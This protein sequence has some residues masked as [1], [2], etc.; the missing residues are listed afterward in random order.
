MI[1]LKAQSRWMDNGGDA[2]ER[3]LM[4]TVT[5]IERTP[6]GVEIFTWSDSLNV[7]DR[8]GFVWRGAIVDF[9]GR[10][11]PLAPQAQPK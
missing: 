8:G 4:H 11:K 7:Q 3:G 5:M 6:A 2:R 10:F 1:E 9:L